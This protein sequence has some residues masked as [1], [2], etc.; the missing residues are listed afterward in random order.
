MLNRTLLMKLWRKITLMM[1]DQA[2]KQLL[3]SFVISSLSGT[4][5]NFPQA[6]FQRN[7]IVRDASHEHDVGNGESPV[8]H[9]FEMAI[10]NREQSV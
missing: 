10:S 5:P 4:S 1:A 7:I 3:S 6:V 8:K 2:I 9:Q